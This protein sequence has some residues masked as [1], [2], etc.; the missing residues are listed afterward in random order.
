M[1]TRLLILQAGVNA[2]LLQ[3]RTRRFVTTDVHVRAATRAAPK[4][5][6][7]IESGILP[8]A[9]RRVWNRRTAP[10]HIGM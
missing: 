7:D 2:A 6:R 10:G 9:V 4:L 1:I 5:L 3:L 8:G